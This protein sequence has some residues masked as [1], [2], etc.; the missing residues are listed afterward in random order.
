MSV[1]ATCQIWVAFNSYSWVE[2][3]QNGGQLLPYEGVSA[4]HTGLWFLPR[5]ENWMLYQA[6]KVG[7]CSVNDSVSW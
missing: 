6:V 5:K 2:L 4:P 3:S 1:C 7:C